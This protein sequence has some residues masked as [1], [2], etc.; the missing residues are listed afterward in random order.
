M[1]S[2]QSWKRNYRYTDLYVQCSN[3]LFFLLKMHPLKKCTKLAFDADLVAFFSQIL[4][5]LSPIIANHVP[6]RQQHP[7]QQ[8]DFHPEPCEEQY[9]V[10]ILARIARSEGHVPQAATCQTPNVLETSRN[11]FSRRQLSFSH[12]EL[13]HR[14][15]SQRSLSITFQLYLVRGNFVE[16]LVL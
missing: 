3:E 6:Q 4:F 13:S 5:D 16:V 2:G 14:R 7:S 15:G 10:F 9:Q 12:H 11:A 8:D 1:A